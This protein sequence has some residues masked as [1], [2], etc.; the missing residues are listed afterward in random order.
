MQTINIE[1]LSTSLRGGKHLI[2][3][4]TNMKMPDFADFLSGGEPIQRYLLLT[5]RNGDMSAQFWFPWNGV[6]TLV[7]ARDWNFAL[8][9]IANAPKPLF[10]LV[11]DSL[12]VPE[13]FLRRVPASVTLVHLIQPSPELATSMALPHYDSV[14]I[15]PIDDI[16]SKFYESALTCLQRVFK[17]HGEYDMKE[18]LRELRVAGAGLVW[19]RIQESDPGGA[20]YWYEP[21]PVSPKLLLSAKALGR[22]MKNFGETLMR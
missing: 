6:L 14:F 12:T 7:D 2:I 8:T 17:R 15:S 10:C 13:A 19:T 5:G 4:G 11:D 3:H 22:I 20:V 18:V 21:G 16:G 9:Y 1:G